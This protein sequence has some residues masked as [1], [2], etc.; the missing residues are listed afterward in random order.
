V[1]VDELAAEIVDR[2]R[3]V[4]SLS[5]LRA[6]DAADLDAPVGE[7]PDADV[8][9]TP[10]RWLLDRVGDGVKLT[11]AGYLPPTVVKAAMTELGWAE[12]WYGKNNR[13]DVTLPVLEL[14]ESAQRFGLVRKYRGQLVPTRIGRTLADDPAGLWWHLA[15]VLPDA[16]SEPQ[17][18]AGVLYLITV[19]AGLAE[20]DVMLAEG[21]TILGWTE[22]GTYQEL[23]PSAAF[24]AARDTWAVFRR[25]GLVP[26]TRRLED[27]VP[28]RA[29]RRLARAALLGREQRTVEATP[30]P[31]RRASE[32]ALQLRVSLRDTGVWR[33]LVVPSSLTLRELHAVLQTAIGWEDYHLH[34]FDVDS[35]LYGDVEEIEGQPLGDEAT[36]TLARAADAVREFVYEYDFGDSWHHD[37]VIEQ[38]MPSVR[39]GTPHLVD[40][41]GACPPEDCGG[42]G[43]FEH[44]LEVLAD[45]SDEEHAE[46]LEW[47]GGSY[48]P[49]AFDIDSVNAALELYDRHTRQRRLRPS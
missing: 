14:R 30:A 10:Y 29:A 24:G 45:P 48:D 1:G 26:R 5:W 13:E 39:T 32:S 7:E 42:T 33:R 47:V 19:A 9:V 11:Q 31:R 17:R 36:F 46:M 25:L 8:V 15:G 21:M 12:D 16:R 23:S 38:A 44:L 34:V 3:S 40:G 20:N 49:G 6:I 28:T 41:A 22:R 37:I 18:H 4:R 2:L 27:G 35:V 43:G